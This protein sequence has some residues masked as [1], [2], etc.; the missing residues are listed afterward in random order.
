MK[1]AITMIMLL[2]I[3]SISIFSTELMIKAYKVGG[4]EPK[5]Y[6]V[7]RISQKTV[8]QGTEI[9]I[10]SDIEE[11]LGNTTTLPNDFNTYVIASYRVEG[12]VTGKY[13][14]SFEMTDFQGPD[15]SSVDCIYQL[16]NFNA[17]FITGSGEIQSNSIHSGYT[18]YTISYDDNSVKT[19]KAMS[20][21][22]AVLEKT[23]TVN[24]SYYANTPVPWSIR[25]AIGLI[26][27]SSQYDS[28]IYGSYKSNVRVF[29]TS[30]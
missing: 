16:G 1:K 29:I 7:D 8:V 19:G 22:P 21:Q 26:I 6:V 11:I 18:N 15:G 9:A 10:T 20:G 12:G 14:L 25:G 27:D 24:P 28:L 17:V 23:W 30:N 4:G 2:T 13:T 5:V 3:A